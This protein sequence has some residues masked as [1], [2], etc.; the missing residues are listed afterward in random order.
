MHYSTTQSLDLFYIPLLNRHFPGTD[1][2][3]DQYDVIVCQIQG[4]RLCNNGAIKLTHTPKSRSQVSIPNI[5]LIY[6][7]VNDV[8]E[9]LLYIYSNTAKKK[10]EDFSAIQV[11]CFISKMTEKN[12]TEPGQEELNDVES[13]AVTD[14][15]VGAL[16]KKIDWIILPPITILFFLSF[17]DR[18]NIGNAKLDNLTVDLNMTSEQ[19]LITLSVFFI[20]YCLFEVPSNIMLKRTSPTFWLPT[21]MLVW[22][23][24]ATL[25]ALSKSFG[26]L[27]AARFFLG[28]TEAGV[29]PGA[30][31]YLSMWYS[32]RRLVTRI[33][34]FFTSTSL[35]GAFGG[36]LAYAIGNMSGITNKP[37]WFW[38]FTIEGLLTIVAAV[39]SYF[40]IQD[41]P[42]KAKFLNDR[43]RKIIDVLLAEANDALRDETFS[44]VEARR[45]FKDPK[46]YLYT[47]SWMGLALPLYTLS[48]FLPTIIANLGYTA[49]NAQLLT[50]PPYA[51]A[52]ILSISVAFISEKYNRRAPFIAGFSLLGVLGYILLLSDG[53]VSVQYL[54]TFLTA[55][56]IYP[57]SALTFT[58]LAC[59]V[60][61]QVK[62]TIATAVQISLGDIGA[63]VGCQMYRPNQSPRYPLGHGM[64]LGFLVLGSVSTLILWRTLQ[65][66]NKRRDEI[67]GG[68]PKDQS[69]MRSEDFKGDADSRW[70]FIV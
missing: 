33:T 42:R 7:R 55:G 62:R 3:R 51:F 66:E 12:E 61:G 54:G 21:I 65:N 23:I 10:R 16:L 27:L 53:K 69:F 6:V 19:Y 31:F 67:T 1:A 43:E 22:G 8:R 5:R 50:V 37:G 47:V 26:G 17:L 15:E 63:V 68:P 60:S 64:A 28:A 58:W 9:D 48:L 20:G 44:W 38:I 14:A 30:I 49:A 36:I 34:L 24:V 57:A 41:V 2:K 18:S 46:V 40:F 39:I 25:M 13:N 29:F 11:F 32:R 35:A 4:S 56:G 52:T 45:A 70:R 59:N